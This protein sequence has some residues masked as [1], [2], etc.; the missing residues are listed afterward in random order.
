MAYIRNDNTLNSTNV[1]DRPSYV[2]SLTPVRD[3]RGFATQSV[4]G[5]AAGSV[6]K[7]ISGLKNGA[8]A[9]AKSS[10]AVAGAKVL[11]AALTG[12][13]AA[14]LTMRA[15]NASLLDYFNDSAN[16]G[17]VFFQFFPETITD[18]RQVDFNEQKLPFLT[19]PIPTFVSA[20]PRTIAFT[21]QFAQEL[22]IPNGVGDKRMMRYT[23]HNFDVAL[24]VQVVRSFAYPIKG[25]I[26]QPLLLTLPGTRIGI[27]SDA[28][29]C[30]LKGYSTTYESFFP[31]GQARIANM[32]L[33]FQ[34]FTIGIDGPR[35]N[36]TKTS[37]ND[38]YQE[39][40]A[41]T[42]AAVQDISPTVGRLT[43]DDPR[44]GKTLNPDTVAL[45]GGSV[46]L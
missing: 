44:P 37:F 34:E 39:Y 18:D 14:E 43:D 3:F 38:I 19:N 45:G 41:K 5:G 2:G 35:G 26:P 24:S 32:N 28:I 15:Q 27:D 36:I 1:K 10:S 40:V 6:G 42:A 16:F 46:P 11:G 20:S 4:L 21:L 17:S 25:F 31:D 22:W 12:V 30:L 29:Y 13:A 8:G 33:S 7:V 23:K 9:A